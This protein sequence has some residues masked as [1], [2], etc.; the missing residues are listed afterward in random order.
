MGRW[1]AN[2][3]SRH[4]TKPE[5]YRELNGTKI[6]LLEE[7]GVVFERKK[8]QQWKN[9]FALAKEYAKQYPSWN[10]PA[11]ILTSGGAKLSSWGDYQRKSHAGVNGRLLQGWKKEMLDAVGFDW[12]IPAQKREQWLIYFTSLKRYMAKGKVPN[13]CYVDE[14]ERHVEGRLHPCGS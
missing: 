12:A 14:E 6:R 2:V 5:R 3:I 7:L 8:D 10:F 13:Q 1:L 11:D 4:I 9:N